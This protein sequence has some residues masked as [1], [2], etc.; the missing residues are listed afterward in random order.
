[1]NDIEDPAD[2]SET[3]SLDTVYAAVA[4]R[5]TQFDNL[6]WQVPVLSLTAQAFLFTIALGDGGTRFSRS[7][8]C[9]LAMIIAFL[10]V[11][12][13][14]KQR[15]AEITDAHWLEKLEQRTSS[16]DDFAHGYSWRDRRNDESADAGFFE[17]L[18]RMKGYATWAWG[19]S[20]FGVAAA[21]TLAVTWLVPE[22]LAV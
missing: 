13:L 18:S 12:L 2:R 1:M 22:W 16:I 9:I 5:R 19:L 10:T 20:L 6:V 14:T 17:L 8:A 3:V 11:Q 15:Q 7:V 4:A 21:V